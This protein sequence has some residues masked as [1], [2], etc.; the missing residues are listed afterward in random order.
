MVIRSL[1]AVLFFHSDRLFDEERAAA[2]RS[3]E[4]AVARAARMKRLAEKE[5]QRE[6]ERNR[7]ERE[8]EERKQKEKY[9]SASTSQ[10]G[11]RLHSKNGINLNLNHDNDAFIYQQEALFMTSAP[12]KPAAGNRGGEVPGETRGETAVYGCWLAPAL[13]FFSPHMRMLP[14]QRAHKKR[15]CVR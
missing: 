10:A 14:D 2:E 13:P 7:R 8:R 9:N 3:A 11:I 15:A 4:E 1:T 5:R 6:Y 12:P